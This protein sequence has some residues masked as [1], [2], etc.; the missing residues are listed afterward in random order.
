MTAEEAS[1][2]LAKG[3]ALLSGAFACGVFLQDCEAKS[4]LLDAFYPDPQCTPNASSNRA[5][6]LAMLEDPAVFCLHSGKPYTMPL[7]VDPAILPASAAC[8]LN[9]DTARLPASLV[10]VPLVA[11]GMI[12]LGALL[13]LHASPVLFG[14]QDIEALASYASAVI[15]LCFERKRTAQVVRGL[16]EDIR[17]LDRQKKTASTKLADLVGISPEICALRERIAKIALSDAPV[18][19]TGETGTGKGFVAKLIHST[20]GRGFGAF[21]EIN[22][23]ALPAPLLE[24][25]LFG[26]CKGAFSGADKEHPGLFR[27]AGKGTVLLDEIGEMPLELQSA[28]LQFL[29]DKKVR[30]VGG[31]QSIPVDVRILAATNRDIKKDI[32]SGKFRE[33]L[34]HRL[35]FV[36]LHLPPLRNREEDIPLLCAKFLEE[37]RIRYSRPD[38]VFDPRAVNALLHCRFTGNIRELAARVERSVIMLDATTSVLLPEHFVMEESPLLHGRN[39]NDYLAE[40][41]ERIIRSTV[42][43][44]EGNMQKSAQTLGIPRRTLARKMQK[45]REETHF[46]Q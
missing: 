23:G 7:G 17:R 5:L 20:G 12:S 1:A 14:A 31:T 24:S 21:M 40:K 42:A 16:S 18:L 45:Y 32:E 41:E 13:L 2:L 3:A 39:L 38:I 46:T 28:L 36:E 10:A 8:L 22:C 35:A 34:Y 29:Q 33:D 43:F 19:I 6:S 30:P 44:F 15:H 27:A 9:P 37:C 26:H 25:E 4:L 11:P